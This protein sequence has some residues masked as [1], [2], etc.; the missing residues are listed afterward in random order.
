LV[1]KERTTSDKRAKRNRVTFTRKPAKSYD[2]GEG[3]HLRS[4]KNCS[5]LME[6]PEKPTEQHIKFMSNKRG[7]VK[8]TGIINPSKRPFATIET[9]RPPYPE[10]EKSKRK[11]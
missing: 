3:S 4:L 9:K 6:K 2:I 1:K 8:K 5:T 7:M 10:K 11:S